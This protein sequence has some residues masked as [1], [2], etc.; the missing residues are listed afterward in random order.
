MRIQERDKER[1]AGLETWPVIDHSV[2]TFP[3]SPLNAIKRKKLKICL[4]TRVILMCQMFSSL[5]MYR[6]IRA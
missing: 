3:K 6:P 4:I 1:A 2:S 5:F